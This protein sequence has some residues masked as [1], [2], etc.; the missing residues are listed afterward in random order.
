M[1][2][3]MARHLTAIAGLPKQIG[4]TFQ[5]TE[6]SAQ[7]AMLPV[8]PPPEFSWHD[9]AIFLLS[10]AAEIEH[11]LMVQY[12]YAANSLGGPQVPENARADVLDWQRIILGVAKEEMGH[13]VTVQNILKLLGGPLHLDREDYPWVSGFY[14]YA[15]TLEPLSRESLA[16]YVVAES[17]IKWPDSVPEQEHRKIEELAREDAEQQVARVGALYQTIIALLS[18]PK[19]IPDALFRAEKYPFQ[20]SWDEWGRGYAAGARGSTSTT[21]PDVLVRRASSRTEAISALKAIAEQGEAATFISADSEESHF[22]RFLQVYR[23][24]SSV[25]EWKPVLLLP[26][27][28]RVAGFGADGNGAIIE[29]FEASLW[30]RLFN[31][32]YRM[33]LSYLA[34]A[35]R[36]PDDPV[37]QAGTGHRGQVLNRMF[38]EMYNLKAIASLLIRLPL[39]GDSEERAGPP[40]QMPYTLNFP[41]VESDFW[42]LHL[43]LISAS[44][45]QLNLIRQN[46]SRSGL[47]Y[48][49]AL[50]KA[51]EQSQTEIE[52]ILNVNSPTSRNHRSMENL[53]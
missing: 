13:L 26:K 32:R 12:L 14:P 8:A 2:T 9:Y 29:H 42:R 3:R 20:A 27:N 24:F 48:A 6:V 18:D 28:P 37:Q 31:L 5:L 39:K 44:S 40:F 34:H 47:A 17:P 38:G 15:F 25:T 43:D 51:D 36:L 7:K 4:D 41:I 10:M 35:F 30:G 46:T 19:K 16:K 22:T 45:E 53:R 50:R 49:E 21:A 1:R 52:T 23:A 33:L 11:S